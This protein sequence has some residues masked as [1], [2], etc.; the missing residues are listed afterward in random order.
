LLEKRV[1][2]ALK[3]LGLAPCVGGVRKRELTLTVDATQ[4]IEVLAAEDPGKGPDGKKKISAFGG[5]PLIMFECQRTARHDTVHMDMV[6]K[7]LVP[8]MQDHGDA[9][10]AAE[11]PGIAAKGL[12]GLRG[13]VE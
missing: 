1:H 10:L 11:P 8:G 2:K 4:G 5:D 12:Q 7:D 9:Q 3:A 6:L 13:T